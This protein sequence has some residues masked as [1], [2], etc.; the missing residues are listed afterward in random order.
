M[1][2]HKELKIPVLGLT[3]EYESG[4]T[5]FGLMIDPENT[6]CFDFE[7]SAG[8]YET[9]LGFT[10]VDMAQFMMDQKPDG[11][12]P[13]EMFE[14]WLGQIKAIKPGQFTV[15]MVDTIG[16]IETGLADF[17]ASKYSNYGFSSRAKF[18][19]TG[20]IFW[21]KVKSYWKQVLTDLASRCETFV[22]TSHLKKVWVSGRPTQQKEPMGKSTLM[23][24]STLYLELS[25]KGVKAQKII[26]LKIPNAVV[27]KTRLVRLIDGEMMPCLPAAFKDASAK[28]VREYIENPP[29]LAKPKSDEKVDVPHLTDDERLQIQ[30]GVASDEAA[31]AEAELEKIR[32]TA[33]AHERARLL[34]QNALTAGLRSNTADSKPA[35]SAPVEVLA[36]GAASDEPPEE[37]PA[38]DIPTSTT[39]STE[40]SGQQSA[41]LESLKELKSLKDALQLNDEKW[42]KVL[43]F[44]HVTTAKKLTADDCE[45]LIDKLAAVARQKSGASELSQWADG[46]M[47][48]N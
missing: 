39:I 36:E 45:Q 10:H 46:A 22:F 38:V 20:G 4:K 21:S 6:I 41:S 13:V 34:R 19:S 5:M 25:R 3:G 8:P 33:A 42:K 7:L 9:A 40:N 26:T 15:I 18:E 24:L 28:R 37:P 14:A 23:E 1:I 27:R 35:E 2:W 43:S 47:V 30:A 48:K 32:M 16:D 31:A 29:N 44:Y 17:V 12:E 11:Y